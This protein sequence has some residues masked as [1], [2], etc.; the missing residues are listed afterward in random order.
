MNP[1]QC[2]AARAFLQWTRD[3]LAAKARV[4]VVTVSNFE[5][6]KSS[7]QR[8]TLDAMRRTF[9]EAGI[10]FT[11]GDAPGVRLARNPA[12]IPSPS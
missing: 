3:D 2:R 5:N 9:E 8:A 10:G 12:P 11:N 4:S 1:D 6:G 7:P